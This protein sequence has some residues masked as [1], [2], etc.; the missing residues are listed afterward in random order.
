MAL[1]ADKHLAFLASLEGLRETRLEFVVSEHLRLS[2]A[3]WALSALEVLGR[4]DRMDKA[5]VVAQVKRCAHPGG[6]YG[7]AEG[8]DPHLLH[9]LSALQLLALCG[10]L[11]EADAEGVG[12]YLRGLQRAD[13]SF[14]GDAWG[15]VDTRFTYCALQAAALVGQLGALDVPG[16]AAFVRRCRN[17]DG[18][19]GA[20]PGGESHAGQVFCCL[21]ALAIAGGLEGSGDDGVDADGLGW[22]LAE[23]Q[24]DSGGLNGRPEK[25]SDVCYSWWILSSLSILGRTHWID[26][27]ALAA[28]ILD[29][30]DD[31]GG[32]IADRPGNMADVYHTFFGLAGLSLLGVLGGLPGGESHVPICPVYALPEPLVEQLRLPRTKLPAAPTYPPP[33]AAAGAAQ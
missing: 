18:G 24:V 28:F 15:E 20:V 16:A 1:H 3:Y 27:A 25:Q 30:Q 26:K 31:V 2:G 13:G 14:A 5:A 10:A 19:F 7:G 8:H 33:E 23:R 17:F 29:C 12:A 9:T 6:G 22:W 4:G 11:G 21:G 32:G